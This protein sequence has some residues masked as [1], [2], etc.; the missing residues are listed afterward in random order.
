MSASASVVVTM[1]SA[2]PAPSPGRHVHRLIERQAALHPHA[3]A[4]RQGEHV[5]SYRELN[6]CANRLAGLLSARALSSDSSVC[7]LLPPCFETVVCQ[8][9]ILKLGAVYIPLDVESPPIRIASLLQDVA[10]DLVITRKMLSH[11]LPEGV[12]QLTFEG[13]G[14]AQLSGHSEYNL[15]DTSFAESPA[16]LFFTSGTTGQ[17]KGVVGTQANLFHYVTTAVKRFGMGSQTCMPT[18]ARL[19]FSISIFDTLCPLAAGGTVVVVQR[20]TLHDMEK[21]CA[22]LESVTMV[23][24]GPSLLNLLVRHLENQPFRTDRFRHIQHLSS[25]GDLVRGTLLEKLKRFFG[26]SELFVIY[27]C[28]EIACMGSHYEVP[29]TETV[30]QTWIGKPFEG[31]EIQL[32]DSSRQP[33]ADGMPGHIHVAGNG[34]CKGYFNR[35]EL[36]RSRF[37]PLQNN[38]FYDTGDLGIRHPDGNIEMLGRSDYQIQLHGIRIEPGEIE[39]HLVQIPSIKEAVIWVTQDGENEVSLVAYLVPDNDAPPRLDDI[40]AHLKQALPKYMIPARYVLLPRLPVNHNLKLDRSALPTPNADNMLG[41]DAE[42]VSAHTLSEHQLTEIWHTVFKRDSI[43][44]CDDFF[45]LGGDSLLA[46]ELLNAVN[47]AFA[48]KLDL[49]ILLTTPT[50]RKLARWLDSHAQH[51]RRDIVTL[52]QGDSSGP[53]LFLIHGAL[54]YKDMTDHL[55]ANLTVC[56]LYRNDESDFLGQQDMHGLLGTHASIEEMARHYIDLIQEY[57][58]QGPY[59]LGGFSMGGMIAYEIARILLQQN[60]QVGPVVM[61]DTHTSEFV[62]KARFRKAVFHGKRLLLA[63]LP[64]LKYLAWKVATS[65]LRHRVKRNENSEIPL[66][67]D[68]REELRRLARNKAAS[69]YRPQPLGLEG[70]LIKSTERPPYEFPDPTL[71][72]SHCF[73]HLQMLSL[74]GDHNEILEGESAV[75]LAHAIAHLIVADSK[76]S[77]RVNPSTSKT[78]HAS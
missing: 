73:D 59:Y 56:A 62:K 32:L 48:R 39:Y 53:T 9:A 60:Q 37:I 68:N 36:T 13:I 24:M 16:Y 52:Q 63:G 21:L 3:P 15:Q 41:A 11:L 25:G 20:D 5:L 77:H 49:A 31:V 38:L 61:I 7:V 35:P 17:P 76:Q 78:V 22:L 29:R 27:G 47:R 70:L 74:Q 51:T 64:H 43:S 71:G 4:L 54:V 72:W 28:T 58:P 44:V 40:R 12:Q 75:K 10:P 57:Q 23:H 1:D 67:R 55:P 30:T 34:V 8:L 42:H 18:I 33:V 26:H 69:G 46:I 50:I 66:S 2:Q 6:A 45:D 19:T 65:L 14:D